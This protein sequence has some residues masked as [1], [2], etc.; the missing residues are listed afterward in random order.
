MES[1][2]NGAVVCKFDTG[3]KYLSLEREQQFL[4][5]LQRDKQMLYLLSKKDTPKEMKSD[6]TLCYWDHPKGQA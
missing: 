3:G 1:L 4:I 2:R 6:V 5:F